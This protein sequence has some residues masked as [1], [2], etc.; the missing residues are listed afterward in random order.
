MIAL[1]R[2]SIF[3]SLKLA[4]ETVSEALLI[5]SVALVLCCIR[6][7]SIALALV[8][9]AVCM[10]LALNRPQYFP[11]AILVAGCLAVAAFRERRRAALAGAFVIGI[12]LAWA[13]WLVR[14]YTHYGAPVLFSTTGYYTTIWENGAGP[15]R[16]GAYTELPLG[17]GSFIREFGV[18]TRSTPP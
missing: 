14:N 13:P 16:P 10:T 3:W 1:S 8:A 4:T 12:S 11:G 6:T 9:G 7:R 18:A 17:D 5:V 15:L 2:P